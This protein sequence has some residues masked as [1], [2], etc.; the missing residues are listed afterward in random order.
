MV[1]AERRYP[2]RQIPDRNELAEARNF[3]SQPAMGRTSSLK[4]GSE[5]VVTHA[6]P[7]VEIC[8]CAA[9]HLVVF[10]LV[11]ELWMYV[12]IWSKVGR[13]GIE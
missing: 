7:S 4:T 6:S 12:W 13:K 3:R 5:V 1:R 2:S 9:D 8:W 10:N 11:G